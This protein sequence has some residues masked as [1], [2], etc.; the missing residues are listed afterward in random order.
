MGLNYRVPSD[1]CSRQS[2][3]G[4]ISLVI[5]SNLLPRQDS[6]SIPEDIVGGEDE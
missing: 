5:T 4:E 6:E 2:L 3:T 1:V